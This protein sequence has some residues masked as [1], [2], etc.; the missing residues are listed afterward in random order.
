M[1]GARQPIVLA[2]AAAKM[3]HHAAPTQLTRMA[4]QT[5]GI[6]AARTAFQPVKDYYEVGIVSSRVQ[7]IQI[8]E[9]I[10][11]RLPAFA[12]QAEINRGVEKMSIDCLQ[13][14]AGQPPRRT[15]SRF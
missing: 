10:I 6:V 4:H 8:D 3:R 7:P 1:I 14:T 12:P 5:R 15:V 11:R 2:A 13:I 9:I